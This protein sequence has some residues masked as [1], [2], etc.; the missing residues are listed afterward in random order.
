[1]PCH[2]VKLGDGSIAIVRTGKPH[3]RK[4]RFCSEGE[5]T[6]LCDFR[7]PQGKTCDAPMC[8]RCA[9][10]VGPNVDYCPDHHGESPQAQLPFEAA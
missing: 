4:C 2:H 5:A 3:R 1:M 6:L 10:P 9:R 7:G 8:A